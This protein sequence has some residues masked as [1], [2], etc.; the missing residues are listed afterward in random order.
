MA[1]HVS[2]QDQNTNHRYPKPQKPQQDQNYC[3]YTPASIN[4]GGSEIFL[5]ERGSNPSAAAS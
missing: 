3:P 4:L 1:K 2:V 5:N